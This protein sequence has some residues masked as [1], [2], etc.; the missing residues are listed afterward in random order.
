MGLIGQERYE[1][2]ISELEQAY[3]IKPH[4]SVL[5]NIARAYLSSGK[6]PEAI[7]FFKRYLAS[8]PPDGESVEA[9][10]SHLEATLP[11]PPPPLVKAPPPPEHP[12]KPATPTAADE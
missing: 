12:P 10:L 3:A 8:N 9:T 1:D 6:I 7:G 5:Y 2:G 4:P 11:A